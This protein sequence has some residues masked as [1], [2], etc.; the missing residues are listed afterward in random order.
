MSSDK[1]SLTDQGYISQLMFNL[2]RVAG[3]L[4]Q[5]AT[6]RELIKSIQENE[7]DRNWI[8]FLREQIDVIL[9][10]TK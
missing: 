2:G 5:P 7:L 1:K 3:E 10:A 9:D 8:V 4:H 6:Q